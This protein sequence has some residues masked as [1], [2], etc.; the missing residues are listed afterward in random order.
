M[1]CIRARLALVITNVYREINFLLLSFFSSTS[2]GSM[3][4]TGDTNDPGKRQRSSVGLQKWCITI[5]NSKLNKEDGKEMKKVITTEK[6]QAIG[7]VDEMNNWTAL[8]EIAECECQ[9]K[10]AVIDWVASIFYSKPLMVMTRHRCD[11]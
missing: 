5:P 9:R 3:K 2:G 11:C 7:C 1:G 10:D 8:L 4:M 6:R